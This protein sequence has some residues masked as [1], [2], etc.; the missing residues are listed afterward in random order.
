MTNCSI[1]WLD[2]TEIIFVVD[3]CAGFATSIDAKN[4]GQASKIMM[5]MFIIHP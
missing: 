2:A 4:T 1:G 3:A 5:A